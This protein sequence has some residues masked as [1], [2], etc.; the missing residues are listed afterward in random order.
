MEKIN[1]GG[2]AFPPTVF[3]HPQTER[4]SSGYEYFDSGMTL[5]DYFAAKVL[6]GSY[7]DP[8][9]MESISNLAESKK[10]SSKITRSIYCYE[11]AD[12]MLAERAK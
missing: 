4:V 12:A 7:S 9:A 3:F 5:R 1:D 8:V 6:A 10:V 11:I 2:P